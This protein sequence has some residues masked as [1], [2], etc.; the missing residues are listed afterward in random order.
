M[1]MDDGCMDEWMRR[2]EAPRVGGA[3]MKASRYLLMWDAA[4]MIFHGAKEL[5]RSNNKLTQYLFQHTLFLSS[6]KNKRKHSQ[7]NCSGQLAGFTRMQPK[8]WN[9][10]TYE[11]SQEGTTRI[12]YE[13]RTGPPIHTHV[14]TLN[15]TSA[16]S[17]T[18]PHRKSTNINSENSSPVHME[19]LGSIYTRSM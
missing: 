12:L 18:Q 2:W 7:I 15:D 9:L 17:T 10:W 11:E 3:Y 13:L 1:E 16:H 5:T 6:G 14:L 8:P 19:R 4:E